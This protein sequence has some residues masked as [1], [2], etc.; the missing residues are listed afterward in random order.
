MKYPGQII[1]NVKWNSPYKGTWHKW[2]SLVLFQGF[3]VVRSWFGEKS[4]QKRKTAL[5]GGS[6]SGWRCGCLHRSTARDGFGGGA[7]KGGGKGGMGV[8][9]LKALESSK[10]TSWFLIFGWCKRF[11]GFQLNGMQFF[12]FFL[13]RQNSWKITFRV[14]LLVWLLWTGEWCGWFFWSKT[15]AVSAD[16]AQLG[17]YPWFVGWEGQIQNDSHSF[18]AR[19]QKQSHHFDKSVLTWYPSMILWLMYSNMASLRQKHGLSKIEERRIAKYL[20]RLREE[21]QHK[22][23]LTSTSLFGCI[24]G[25]ECKSTTVL[26]VLGFCS[27]LIPLHDT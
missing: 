17:E 11:M 26:L 10:L 6:R 5:P 9:G 13:F 24:L 4:P 3:S 19:G 14:K 16:V 25:L 8:E 22:K 12:C 20:H 23:E 27:L 18:S 1:V 7:K 15:E 21:V 2:I